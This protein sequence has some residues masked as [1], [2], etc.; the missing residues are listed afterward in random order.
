MQLLFPAMLAGLAGLSVPVILHLIARSRFPVLSVPSIR[1]LR[2]ER[3]DNVFARKLVD[4][5]QL[6]LRLLVIAL[7]VLAMSRVFLPG[8]QTTRSARNLVVILDASAS[9]K[10]EVRH[11]DKGRTMVFDAAKA[12]AADLLADIGLPSRCALLLVGDELNVISPLSP[13][14][15]A[16]LAALK[17]TSTKNLQPGDGSGPGLVRAIAQACEMLQTRR[18]ANSQIVVITDLRASAFAT[19]NQRDLL[20]IE[21]ARAALGDTLQIVLID[22]G[23]GKADN[24]AITSAHLRND[25]ARINDDALVVA[26]VKNMGEGKR[27]AKL[28]LLVAG[29]QESAVREFPL[30]PG[31]EVVVDLPSRITRS[32]R[33]FAAVML[34][35][36]DGMLHDNVFSVPFS[37]A[38]VRRVL[39]VDG[40]AGAE[41]K[42]VSLE[43]FAGFGSGEDN[44]ADEQDEAAVTGPRILQ[45]ALNPARELHMPYGTG[46]ESDVATPE[47]LPAE[48]LSKYDVI[49]LYD[50]STLKDI[51][52][53]DLD[54]FVRDGRAVVLV[55]SGLINPI[56][57]N[58]V[59]AAAEGDRLALSPAQMGNDRVFS[60]AISVRLSDPRGADAGDDVTYQPG[61]WLEPFRD[62]R[63]GTLQTLRIVKAREL[64]AIEQ[65]ANVLLQGSGG[66]ALA[67]EAARGQGR[68]VL[69]NFGLEL[70]RGNISMTREFPQLMWRLVDYLTGK[71]RCK[72]SD[73]LT[74]SQP[75]AL[76]AS[77]T[78]FSLVEELEMVPAAQ[79]PRPTPVRASAAGAADAAAGDG[80]ATEAADAAAAGGTAA[81]PARRETETLQLPISPQGNV[82]VG[83]LPVGHYRLQKKKGTGGYF[84]PVAVN[85]DM[86]ESDMACI[87]EE[88]LQQVLPHARVVESPAALRKRAFGW[89]AWSVIV[90]LLML[91]YAAEAI[92]AYVLNML[93]ERKKE[94]EAQATA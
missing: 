92:C 26:R 41:Q 35:E 34:Q 81:E 11:P 90:A 27:T 56:E 42:K 28:G 2:Y 67:V 86:S 51:S 39:I 91:A 17:D 19:R 64:R 87:S 36:E 80:T 62:R 85:A 57:F 76:D 45:F 32:A 75:S 9:M 29:K 10:M 93:R 68:V 1:L 31:Q 20:E 15:S 7:L 13:D 58:S 89:E 94:A 25:R 12:A 8:V 49:I 70:N 53:K 63:Q 18:E 66:E 77:E 33:S 23:T 72:P 24:L 16:A 73:A 5:W 21:R 40:V 48:T 38:P 84:R 6:L 54:T 14:A 82:M 43:A 69:L 59:F 4:H 83:G 30:E 3:R 74:A 61:P 50:V 88:H 52:R 65:G 46:I 37:V 55:C 22:V 47:T 79:D 71:L 60:P 44:A 78:G